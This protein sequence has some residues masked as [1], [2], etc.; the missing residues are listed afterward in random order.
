MPHF[1]YKGPPTIITSES[2]DAIALR[3][4]EVVVLAGSS[5]WEKRQ[6]AL[7]ILEPAPKPEPIVVAESSN[8]TKGGS[9]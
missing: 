6:I 7:G 2:G 8:S 9:K 1:L 4:N 3:T 5:E